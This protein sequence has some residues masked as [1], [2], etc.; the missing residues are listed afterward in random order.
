MPVML[1]AGDRERWLDNSHAIAA[2][3][4]LF[5][6]RLREPLRLLPIEKSVGNARNKE[7]G[8]L[9]VTGEAVTLSAD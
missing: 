5:A 3:D 7:P 9:Q 8:C 2:D 1:A 6:P 4:P